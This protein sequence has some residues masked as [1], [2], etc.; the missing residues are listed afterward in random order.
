M[1]GQSLFGD[2]LK[3]A[4]VPPASV[5]LQRINLGVF[6]ILGRLN[7]TTDWRGVA[8]ELWPSV[9]GPPRTELGEQEARWL[10]T[11]RQPST[12]IADAR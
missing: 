11:R 8:E 10:A 4:R 5:I 12:A 2:V 9:D 1:F 7:A 3:Y 6:A